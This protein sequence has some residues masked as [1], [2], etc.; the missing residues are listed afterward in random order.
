MK[1]VLIVG[2]ANGIGLAFAL[3]LQKTDCHINVI[4]K[5]PNS[6]FDNCSNIVFQQVNLLNNDFSFLERYQDIN[7]GRICS[8]DDIVEPEI[9]NS[10]QVNTIS[11]LKV[12]HFFFPKM[13]QQTPFH[14]VVMG[15]IAGMV[16]SPL[17]TLYGATKAAL[18]NAIES[19]NIELEM[20]GTDNRILHVAPGFIK[21]TRFYGGQNNI[22]ET[23]SLARDILKQMS[24]RQ[25]L[26]IPLYDEVYHDVLRRYHQDSHRF[27][28]ESYHYK[29]DS[30]RVRKKP[31][32]KVGY[33]SGTFD[34]FHIGHLNLLRR[35][36]Q[37]CDY[38]VVGVHKDASHKGKETF[39]PLEE[40]IDI[41]SSVRYVDKVIIAEK[42][43][44][45]V[46]AKGIVHYDYLFVGSDYKGS[47]RF[48]G[49]EKYFA[50]KDVSIIYFPYTKETNSTQLREA[51][52]V[53][54]KK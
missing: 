27:G 19:L 24:T 42:E 43:D 15:S 46:Y 17:L 1:K 25:T 32:M 41:V 29:V 31:Q 51:L 13:K 8:F 28:I 39:I 4:D 22:D 54:K 18:S 23:S 33:L 40:R 38:L 6:V 49:Y 52:S 30:D 20:S 44:S 5:E 7:I 53:V 14:C 37:Y 12:L 10:F 47:D 50:D 21:G 34:L 2:G 48:N 35:A 16:C 11:A 3:E 26:F 36:K 9:Q 45:D